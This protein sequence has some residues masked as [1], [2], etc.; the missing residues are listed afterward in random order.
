M[1]FTNLFFTAW[2]A[3]LSNPRRA[4]LTMLGIIIGSASVISMLALGTGAQAAVEASFRGLGSDTIE[5]AARRE[6]EDGE[7]RP[8]GKILSY[9]DGLEMGSDLVLIKRVEMSIQARERVR[10]G[11]NVLDHV[12]IIGSSTDKVIQAIPT[13]GIQPVNWPEGE[14]LTVEMLEAGLIAEGRMF[15]P[16]ELLAG[17]PVCV[18][19]HK[20]A[21]D[22]FDGDNALNETIWVKRARCLVIGVLAEMEFI[23]PARR[24]QRNPNE[25]VLVPIGAAIHELYE[26]EPSVTITAH[27]TDE[28]RIDEAKSEV[29]GYLRERHRIEKNFEGVYV[30]DFELVTRKDVLG[31]QRRAARTLSLMLVSM[32]IVSLVVGGIGIMNVMLV[33]VTERTREIGVR[34]A[35]GARRRDIV[36]QFLFEAL[37][38]SIIGGLLGIAVGVLSVPIIASLNEGVALLDA[39]SI[40]LAFGVALLTGL[41]F[42]SYPAARAARL[43]PIEALRYE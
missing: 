25:F 38:L 36:L 15:S 5:I 26:E 19:A 17:A 23:D 40:P 10:Y 8:I 13:G 27:V 22:L 42:G 37:L 20:T 11:R 3:L 4:A 33:S 9:Q 35:V 39:E 2:K 28:S 30:D 14:L 29:A 34:M 31:A 12:I 1:T 32:A 43:D 41:V 18:L 16:A 6:I 24:L 21:E 7:Y